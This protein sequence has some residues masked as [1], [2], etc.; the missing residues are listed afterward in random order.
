MKEQTRTTDGCQE[1]SVIY[2]RTNKADRIMVRNEKSVYHSGIIR[3][4]T[5]TDGQARKLQDSHKAST[6]TVGKP[7][8]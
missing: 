8:Q 2:E 4:V 6:S 1:S 3:L 7:Y 5:T